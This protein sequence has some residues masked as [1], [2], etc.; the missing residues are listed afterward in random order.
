MDDSLGSRLTRWRAP[1][2]AS[3]GDGVGLVMR[4]PRFPAAA[5]RLSQNM[6]AITRNN[7]SLDA[8]VKDAG[9]F[10]ATGLAVH[11][12]ATGGLTLPRLKEVCASTTF[13]SPGRARAILLFLR[14]LRY[15]EPAGGR[16][17]LYVP[18]GE[19]L[20]AWHTLMRAATEAAETVEPA[21]T[22]ISNRLA[23][24]AFMLDFMRVQGA[25]ALATLDSGPKDNA[26]WRVVLNRHAGMQLMHH[27]MLAVPD[28]GAYP[29]EEPIAYSAAELAR[30]LRVS[31]PHIA[32][33]IKAGER[34]GLFAS[35]TE[36]R[37]SLLAPARH[38]IG[39][40]IALRLWAALR[41]AAQLHTD[42]D[43]PRVSEVS[44]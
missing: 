19:L 6:L 4:H 30:V 41:T 32:R 17:A 10:A 38:D 3:P 35:D 14:F 18:T 27:L 31:R 13:I 25:L 20:D 42:R 1:V 12:H 28:T 29:P 16:P 33:L 43:A 2:G 15:V 8:I 26:F 39:L 24:R 21:M 34:E 9:R 5:R 23:D 11:L 7:A 36:G 40:V 22:L 37:V 44:V